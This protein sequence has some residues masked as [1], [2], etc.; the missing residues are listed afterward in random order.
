[1]V[2]VFS[3]VL[4]LRFIY[5]ESMVGKGAEGKRERI[6]RRLHAKLGA[7]LGAVSHNPEITT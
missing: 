1:M 3:F 5:L 7:R 4:F 6:S 2:F